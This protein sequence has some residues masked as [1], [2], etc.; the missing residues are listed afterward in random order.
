M[1]LLSAPVRGLLRASCIIVTPLKDW[2]DDESNRVIA[3][4]LFEYYVLAP[5]SP[6]LQKSY[7]CS[8][9]GI[10]QSYT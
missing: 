9:K 6:L 3:L 5:G 1:T 7:H 10:K 8:V 4:S 2:L